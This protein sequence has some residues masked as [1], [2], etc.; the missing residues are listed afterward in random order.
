MAIAKSLCVANRM[1]DWW[2]CL[3][4]ASIVAVDFIEETQVVRNCVGSCLL[5]AARDHASNTA[6][7]ARKHSGEGKGGG[8]A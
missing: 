8:E 1:A 5:G 4:Q 2:I 3:H 6:T 7:A